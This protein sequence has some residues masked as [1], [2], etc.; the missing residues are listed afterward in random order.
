MDVKDE[1]KRAMNDKKT[2]IGSKEVVSAAKTGN[3]SKVFCAV[4][5]PPLKADAMK[6]YAKIKG[7][8]V[9]MFDGNSIELGRLCGKPFGI[10][11]LGIRQ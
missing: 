4:N 11:M 8:D 5:I 10:L 6:H 2:V 1:I 9:I 3:L 7:F